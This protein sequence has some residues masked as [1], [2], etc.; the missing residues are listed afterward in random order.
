MRE[1]NK[2]AQHVL[3]DCAVCGKKFQHAGKTCKNAECKKKFRSK[4]MSVGRFFDSVQRSEEDDEV[5]NTRKIC[6]SC[7]ISTYGPLYKVGEQMVCSS[8]DNR[9]RLS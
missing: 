8:C 9:M 2:K 4:E 3:A 7:N 5:G 1:N 6:E